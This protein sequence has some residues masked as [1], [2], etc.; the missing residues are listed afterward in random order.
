MKPTKNLA[1]NAHWNEIA[2]LARLALVASQQVKQPV[3]SNLYVPEV[4]HMVTLIAA[5][6]DSL[7]R[8]TVWGLIVDLVNSQW[9]TRPTDPAS[10]E[11]RLL[12]EE[13]SD[14][15][16]LRLFG[17]HRASRTSELIAH[18]PKNEKDLLDNQDGLTRFLLRV[19]ECCAQPKGKEYCFGAIL[20]GD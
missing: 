5:T 6:G 16:T 13:C 20:Q 11:I 9:I 19:M 4:I 3:L 1:D 14:P 18:D 15:K 10:P 2:S 17:L 8:C 12:F 7:V